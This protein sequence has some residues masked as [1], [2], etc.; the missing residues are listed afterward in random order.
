MN[1]IRNVSE[2]NFDYNPLSLKCKNLFKFLRL[3]LTTLI[4]EFKSNLMTDFNL[5][6][7]PEKY[8]IIQFKLKLSLLLELS[9][10]LGHSF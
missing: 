8:I 5:I 7:L 6:I 10:I 3:T 4:N 1:L 9:K 2:W